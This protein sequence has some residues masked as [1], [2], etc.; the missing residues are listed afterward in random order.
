MTNVKFQ[1]VRMMKYGPLRW[2]QPH[3]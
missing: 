1:K 2:L 3:A